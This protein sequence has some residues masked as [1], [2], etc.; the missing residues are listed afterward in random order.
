MDSKIGIIEPMEPHERKRTN[1]CLPNES[2]CFKIEFVTNV[3]MIEICTTDEYQMK[4][5]MNIS[6][7]F[8]KFFTD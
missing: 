3:E 6:R 4:V 8:R 5:H 2:Q 1:K 7:T